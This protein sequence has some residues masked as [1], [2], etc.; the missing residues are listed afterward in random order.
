MTLFLR[1]GI[2]IANIGARGPSSPLLLLEKKANR[3]LSI[4][5]GQLPAFSGF[6]PFLTIDGRVSHDETKAE[7]SLNDG[8]PLLLRMLKNRGK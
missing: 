2:G 5:D 8:P 7:T 6:K 1:V 4:V 3:N